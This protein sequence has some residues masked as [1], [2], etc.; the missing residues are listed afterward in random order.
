MPDGYEIE[1]GLDPLV[2]DAANDN[3]GDG[4]TNLDEFRRGTN[5]MSYEIPVL[6]IV[7]GGASVVL[8]IGGGVYYYKRHWVHLGGA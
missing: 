4:V 1:Y 7:L 8:V 6:I 2:D 3:D 5:P